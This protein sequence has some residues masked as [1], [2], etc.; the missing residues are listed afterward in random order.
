MLGLLL[1]GAAGLSVLAALVNR[2]AAAVRYLA[3]ALLLVILWAALPVLGLK[4]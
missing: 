1:L 3:L 4:P 2:P